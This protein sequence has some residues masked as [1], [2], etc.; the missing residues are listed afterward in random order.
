MRVCV[1]FH[2]IAHDAQFCS[3][4]Q[5]FRRAHIWYIDVS[6]WIP[7]SN[8]TQNAWAPMWWFMHWAARDTTFKWVST[9]TQ[10]SNWKP[11]FSMQHHLTRLTSFC[12]N[13]ALSLTQPLSVD[14]LLTIIGYILHH[15]INWKRH[16]EMK[17]FMPQHFNLMRRFAV[18]SP[19]QFEK[20][21]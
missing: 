14:L 16:R 4:T 19:K 10:I 17:C 11:S 12:L 15:V 2:G 8:E 18:N 3:F 9:Y 13:R 1:V 5:V 20:K 6:F 7:I 21:E